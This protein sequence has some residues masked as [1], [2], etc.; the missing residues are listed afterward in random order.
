MFPTPK[1]AAL[2]AENDRLK[3]ENEWLRKHVE[4]PS[5]TVTPYGMQSEMTM[6]APLDRLT[7]PRVASVIGSH[8][9]IDKWEVIATYDRMDG[10]KLRVDYFITEPMRIHMDDW[11]FI[12]DILPKMHERFIMQLGD[13]FAREHKR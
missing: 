7:L 4:A 3:A 12:N 9:G 1:E 6:S 10:K 5:R 2:Q 13:L 8:D 11:R